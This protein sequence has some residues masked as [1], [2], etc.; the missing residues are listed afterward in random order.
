MKR[1]MELFKNGNIWLKADFHLHTKADKE[2]V[3]E[4]EENDF[5]K[6]YVMKLKENKID[7]GVITNH[8]KF[9]KNEFKALKKEALKEEIFLLAGVELSVNDAANG[10]HCLIVFDYENWIVNDTNFIEQFLISA[11][12]GIANRENKN[13]NCKYNLT[14]LFEKLEKH[15]KDSR[16]SFIVM[17]HVE[18]NSGFYKE[19]GGGR[20]LQFAKDELF[21]RNVLAFQKMRTADIENNLLQWFG[22]KDKLP[23]FVEG[24]DCKNMDNVGKTG[25]QK[26]ENGNVEKLTYFKIGDF[27][28]SA[29]RYALTDKNNRIKTAKPIINNSYIKSISFEGGLLDGI[30]INLSSE[31]NNFIGIRGSGKSSILEILRYTLGISLS[32]QAV[33]KNYKNELI[34]YILKSGGKVKLIIINEHGKEYLIEKIY[35]QKEDIFENGT[36]IDAS[37]SAVFKQPVYFGQKDLSNKDIDFEADLVNKLIGSRLSD[38]RLKITAKEMEIKEIIEKYKKLDNLEELKKETV[39]KLK[40]A[41]HNLRLFEEKGVAE[42]LRRQS[43]F[44]SDISKLEKT[45]TTTK[46]FLNDLNSLIE[47]YKPFFQQSGF[48]SEINKEIFEEVTII[49]KQIGAEFETLIKSTE[50]TKELEDNF[51]NIIDRLKS[52]KEEL[53]DEFGKIKREINIP[54][55]NPEEF[56][57][58]NRIIET[59]KLKLKEIDNSENKRQGHLD[60]LSNKISELNNLWHEEYKIME[61]EVSRINEF[62]KQLTIVVVYKGR[63]DK[64]LDKQQQIFKGS[65]ITETNYNKIQEKYKDFIEIYRDIGTL[66]NI[67][68]LNHLSEYNKKFSENLAELL[69]YQ[70]ENKF[71]IKYNDKLLK[72]HSLGQ[73]ATALILFLLAQKETDIL[74]IDQPEDDLD[75]QTI[76]KDVIKEIKSLKG[77]MQFIFATHNANIPV[78]GDSEKIFA[79]VCLENKI[80]VQD[81]TIDNR[82]IQ[83][84]IVSIMEGGEEAFNRRK[85]IYGL[86]KEG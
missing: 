33:D 46:E 69:T 31:L 32:R 20:K 28:F 62:E 13:T 51:E 2:F 59:S 23:A 61:K 56:L 47:N 79:C 15:R 39:I 7:I 49:F 82:E 19:L 38:I 21:I 37:I 85:D 50:K 8:N 74:I 14:S 66:N 10:I 58:L 30:E 80:D 6:S 29:V 5:V 60:V 75:N 81:G 3:Y 44:D 84:A 24:S 22:S 63:R 4:G 64:F 57:N 67:L 54:N 12:E 43:Q 71:I 18:Q 45:G 52:K 77:D 40:D 73:R 35:G 17:A 78:L 26:D 70:V 1:T 53:K 25:L 34:E 9:D 16:D 27:N 48:I 86:W 42:K 76:Y 65:G 83:K 36:R 41:E 55:L 68:N 72:E 11:F